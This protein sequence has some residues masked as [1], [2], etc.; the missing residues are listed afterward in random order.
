[1]EFVYLPGEDG[2]L[3]RNHDNSALISAKYCLTPS[4]PDA[5]FDDLTKKMTELY[6][7]MVRE[8]K[9]KEDTFRIW[10]G[11][12][13]TMVTLQR[14][15]YII[16]DNGVFIRYTFQGADT[17]LDQAHEAVILEEKNNTESN[18]NGL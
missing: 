6:G 3:I 11:T 13:G 17:L 10:E 18:Y 5:A 8:N 12:N 1:M 15:K 2:S 7:E 16:E 14:G 4:D 9:E